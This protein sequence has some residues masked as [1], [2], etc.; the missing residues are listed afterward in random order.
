MHKDKNREAL[1]A[2]SNTNSEEEV[3]ETV[4]MKR[5]GG[6]CCLIPDLAARYGHAVSPSVEV[7]YR[8][9]LFS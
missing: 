7:S 8:E 5:G 3:E 1:I 4:K 2:Y 9:I 6:K